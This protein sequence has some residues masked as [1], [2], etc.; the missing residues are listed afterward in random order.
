MAWRRLVKTVAAASAAAG[1]CALV[2]ASAP[3]AAAAPCPDVEVV[4]A[5]G[6]GEP[7]GVGGIGG[8]FV[9]AVRSR[10][11]DRSLAVYAVNYPASTDFGSSDFPLTVIDGIRDAGG[12]IQAMATNCPTTREVLGGYSQGAAVAGY[13]TS[14]AVPAG[15]P[16]SAVPAPLAPEIAD[17]VA[18]VTLFGAPS[19][20]FLASYGAPPLAIGPP[21]QAKTI[22]LCANGDGICGAGA[23]PVSHALY[24]V[25]GMT[26]QAADFATG[27]L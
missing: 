2:G 21:Y 25:N 6:S 14:A 1:V 10:I 22:S 20:Q 16:A 27:R 23:S 7:P 5:R 9:D 17:H 3:T 19:D 18:A 11:G 26:N 13:V 4:F 8:A 24:A 12:H 15:V